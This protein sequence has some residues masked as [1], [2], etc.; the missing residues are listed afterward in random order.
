[1]RLK[2]ETE[3][4]RARGARD[5]AK[6]SGKKNA[7][8]VRDGRREAALN[9]KARYFTWGMRSRLIDISIVGEISVQR[10][11]HV[12]A[13]G[14]QKE[15]PITHGTNVLSRIK[16]RLADGIG[17]R[18]NARFRP[19]VSPYDVGIRARGRRASQHVA[20]HDALTLKRYLITPH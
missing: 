16:S 18:A 13:V 10:W 12:R 17:P 1:M 3:K 19:L 2:L 8:T 5:K 7:P 4:G 14:A 15:R 6:R 20:Q 9:F 11:E